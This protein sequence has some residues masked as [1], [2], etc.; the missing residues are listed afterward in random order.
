LIS[1]LSES[2]FAKLNFLAL[3]VAFAATNLLCEAL[4]S[5]LRQLTRSTTRRFSTE[6]AKSIKET[7]TSSLNRIVSSVP[8]TAAALFAGSRIAKAAG[9][10][11]S[12]GLETVTNKVYFDVA[13]DGKPQGRIVIGLFGKAVPKTVENFRALCTG[14]KGVSKSSGKALT[15]EGSSFHRIIPEFMIQGGDFTRGDGRGGESIY[16]RNF[17]DE[18]FKLQHK[19]P[20]YVSM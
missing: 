13:I 2:M 5:P 10:D 15:Y 20:G 14:E 9:E 7:F 17:P 12:D 19:S 6:D 18:N 16:G 4:R 8:V 1:N 3:I 11:S